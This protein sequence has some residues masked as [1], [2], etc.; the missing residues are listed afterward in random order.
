VPVDL[1][2]L[3]D[4]FDREVRV[5]PLVAIARNAPDGSDDK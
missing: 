3:A 4:G 1:A 5:T 2:V